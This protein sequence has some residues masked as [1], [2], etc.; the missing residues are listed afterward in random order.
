MSVETDIDGAVCPTSTP[1]IMPAQKALDRSRPNVSGDLAD[2]LE[3]PPMF[4]RALVGYDRFQVDTYVRWAEDELVA[5]DREREHLE[6]RHLQTRA[7][8]ADARRLLEHSSGGAEMLRMSQRAGSM[9]AAAAD[10]AEGIRTEAAAHRSTAAAEA[11]RRLGYARWRIS[12]A[13]AKAERLLA[14]AAAETAEMAASAAQ[15]VAAAEQLRAGVQTEAEV[16]LAEVRAAEQRAAE[17]AAQVRRRAVEDAAAARL[18][19]RHEIVAML[20][21][22]REQRLRADAEAAAARGRQADELTKRYAPLMAEVTVL[23]HRRASLRAGLELLAQPADIATR[24]GLESYLSRLLMKLRLRP[25]SLRT[26]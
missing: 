24:G 8:L 5:A 15:I 6:G 9:L 17:D 3:A 13:E 14:E 18:Q 4:R 26:P 25:R 20:S 2:V 16:R 7:D 21:T 19:T 1:G 11:N 10:E 22:A 12:Y 23:E